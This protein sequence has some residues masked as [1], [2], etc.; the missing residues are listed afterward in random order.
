MKITKSIKY[1]FL[2]LINVTLIVP[3]VSAAEYDIPHEFEAGTPALAS[4]VNENFSQAKSA[5]DDN[6]QAIENLTTAPW[7]VKQAHSYNNSSQLFYDGDYHLLD[8]GGTL[9]NT[10]LEISLDYTS[11]IV[12]Q[13]MAECA[14]YA[15]DEMTYI[16]L[17]IL[18]DGVSIPPTN[19]DNALCTSDGSHSGNWTSVAALGIAAGMTSDVHTVQARVRFFDYETG[20]SARLDD[21]AVVVTATA[22]PV[23]LSGGITD[24]PL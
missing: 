23:S 2:V 12:V 10:D 8:I 15:S 18:V 3:F 13:F 11:D 20:E 22:K 21:I 1:T 19:S 9:T 6:S 7:P 24:E 14:V 5:I 17:D 16:D 4:E